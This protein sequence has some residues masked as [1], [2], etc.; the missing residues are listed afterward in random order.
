MVTGAT[1][2]AGR[3]MTKQLTEAGFTVR[4][5]SRHP[6]EPA[7][8]VTPVYFDWYDKKT[9]APALGTA[10]G[11]VVKG[12]EVDRYAYE[13]MELLIK[14]SPH[15][16]RVVF[17]SNMGVEH[18]PDDHPRRAIETM[19]QNSGKVWTILRANWFMQNF[20]ED[21]AVFAHAIRTRGELHAPAGSAK[22]S[23][24][25]TR[26]L[27]AATAAVF[28]NEGHDAKAYAITGPEQLS[29][30]DV[31][32]II[33][34]ARGLPVRHIDGTLAEHR[35]Y[36][37]AP[38]RHPAYVNHINTLYVNTKA[39][40]CAPVSDDVE[41]LTGALPRTLQAYVDETWSA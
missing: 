39:G 26:D 41:R 11:V 23:F 1:G 9:W 38:G 34:K 6:G 15:L 37:R 32:D 18:A 21:D 2:K 19:V 7:E 33:G 28:A 4:A 5:A 24:L 8:R 20:D 30:G 25:D 36:M 31:A 16:R 27:A 40:A 17:L 35:E 29:F 14:S 10:E 3:Q 12:L 13:T 22:V